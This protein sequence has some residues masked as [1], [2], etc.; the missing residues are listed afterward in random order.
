VSHLVDDGLSIL[1]Y[2]DDTILFIEDDIEQAKNL[3][4]ILCVF[5]KLSGPKIN[6]HKSEHFCLGEASS[7]ADWYGQNFG[8][9]EGS[10]PFK[11][12]GIPMNQQ[13][14]ANKDWC[15]IEERFQKKLSSWKGKLL[16]VGE[17]LVFINSILIRL[18]CLCCRSL[19]FLKGFLRS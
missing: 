18:Q 3:K 13:K 5:E 1:Q 10:F 19:E 4:L 15:K 12:L 17:R 2:T 14:I 16:S 8:C 9:R 6:F 11:Y 7:R